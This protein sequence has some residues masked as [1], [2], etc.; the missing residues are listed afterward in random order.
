MDGRFIETRVG[1]ERGGG[2]RWRGG[3]SMLMVHG[4]VWRARVGGRVVL[5]SVGLGEGR[6]GLE[7]TEA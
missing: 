4:V 2:W 7:K 5:R 6:E 3:R 1:E